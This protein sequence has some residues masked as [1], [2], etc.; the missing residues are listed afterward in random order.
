[1]QERDGLLGRRSPWRKWCYRFIGLSA[2]LPC[3]LFWH[4]TWFKLFH[5]L[6]IDFRNGSRTNTFIPHRN[7]FCLFSIIIKYVSFGYPPNKISRL[8]DLSSWTI[9]APYM[10]SNLYITIRCF[11]KSNNDRK[12]ERKVTFQLSLV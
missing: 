2:T 6:V 10:R 8:F 11:Y 12:N 7:T 9:I 1:M 4:G 5:N 3:N